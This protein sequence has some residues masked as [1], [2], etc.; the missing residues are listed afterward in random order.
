MPRG[1]GATAAPLIRG[2]RRFQVT[3]GRVAGHAQHIAL[4]TLS[5]LVAELRMATQLIIACDPAVRHLITPGVE[6]LQA[7]R[8]SRVILHLFWHVACLASWLVPCPLLRQ[9][10]AEVE[11]GM[12]MA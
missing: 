5:E 1:L 10:Q 9:G 12:I 11:H 2:R 6:Y 3:N 7:L 8:L 4:A